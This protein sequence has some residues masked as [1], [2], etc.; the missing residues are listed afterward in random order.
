LVPLGEDEAAPEGEVE[1]RQPAVG[2]P[3]H[4]LEAE[5]GRPRAERRSVGDGVYVGYPVVL[6]RIAVGHA[7]ILDSIW[8]RQMANIPI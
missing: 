7:W 1:E 6:G 8:L 4:L 3:E 2:A 5:A